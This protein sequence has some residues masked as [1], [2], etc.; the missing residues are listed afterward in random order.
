VFQANIDQDHEWQDDS[1]C[2]QFSH[3]MTPISQYQRNTHPTFET[4]C[5]AR[6]RQIQPS[7]T[8]ESEYTYCHYKNIEHGIDKYSQR[9][10]V[11]DP[12]R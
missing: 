4:K 11:H 2:H 9:Q 7:L 5:D 8:E 1:A 6:I 3:L 12:K 10:N